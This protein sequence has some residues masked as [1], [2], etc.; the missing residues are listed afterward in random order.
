MSS[1]LVKSKP[2]RQARGH[3]SDD[4]DDHDTQPEVSATPRTSKT[5]P[6]PVTTKTP[7]TATTPIQDSKATPKP[8]ATVGTPPTPPTPS[9]KTV[10]MADI[11]KMMAQTALDITQDLNMQHAKQMQTQIDTS[12][13]RHAQEMQQAQDAVKNIEQRFKDLQEQQAR[14]TSSATD[15]QSSPFETPRASRPQDLAYQK[16]LSTSK[17]AKEKVT[18]TTTAT[19]VPVAQAALADTTLLALVAMMNKYT[20]SKDT[21]TDLPKFTG[22]DAQWERWYELLRS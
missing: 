5:T 10:T 3:T 19:P 13:T 7:E 12:N 11:K 14:T 17:K 18:D 8:A 15:S 4:D 16:I 22:K 6:K 2:K 20:D 1:N 21:T 9:P